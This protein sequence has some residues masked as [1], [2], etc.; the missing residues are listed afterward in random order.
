MFRLLW[1]EGYSSPIFFVFLIETVLWGGGQQGGQAEDE[2]VIFWDSVLIFCVPYRVRFY[3]FGIGW[4]PYS[5]TEPWTIP[6]SFY[7]LLC[8]VKQCLDIQGTWLSLSRWW[9]RSPC[10][11]QP[12]ATWSPWP[13]RTWSPCSPPA[14]RRSYPTTCWG[15]S[16]FLTIV[17]FCSL[18][19]SKGFKVA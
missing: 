7:I 15:T 3:I 16:K 9:T 8:P 5:F 10:T 11:T 4:V 2:I 19:L 18:P 13:W 6:L 17:C 12:T 14:P 1:E